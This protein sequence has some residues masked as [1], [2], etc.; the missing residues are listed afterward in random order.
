MSVILQV[1]D[2]VQEVTM[3]DSDICIPEEK[4]YININEMNASELN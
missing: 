2:D 3:F 1:D 4:G